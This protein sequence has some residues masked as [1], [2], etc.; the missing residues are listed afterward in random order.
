MTTAAA[1]RTLRVF[2]SSTFQDMLAERDELTTH[3][4][5]ALRLLCREH[6]VELVEVD[7][8]WGITENQS[9]HRETLKL[10]L[11]EIRACRPFFIGLLGERYGWV[12]DENAFTADL[13][14]EEPWLRDL[15]QKS[16]TELEILHGVLNDPGRAR[17]ASLYF[18]DPAF[19]QSLPT[20]RRG[21]YLPEDEIDVGR[22]AALKARI[23]TTCAEKQIALRDPYRDPQQLWL[24]SSPIFPPPWRPSSRLRRRRTPSLARRRNTRA[25]LRPA[26]SPTSPAPRISPPSSGTP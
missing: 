21:K 16:V 17:R 3:T 6:Q 10:C 9:E 13:L 7:L 23:R 25:S 11:D 5:P 22:Q 20:D 26:D 4:W 1:L 24:L 2:V 14:E 8:R 12:P 15:K 18:R 19:I